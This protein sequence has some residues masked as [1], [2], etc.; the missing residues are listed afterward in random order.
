MIDNGIETVCNNHGYTNFDAVTDSTMS[1]SEVMTEINANRPFTVSMTYG[2]IA[3]GNTQPYG[4]HTVTCVGY[5]D[6]T[7]TDALYLHD[8]WDGNFVHG[9]TFGNW[10]SVVA[11]WVRP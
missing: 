6:G 8:T 9:I 2:G 3:S 4:N 1:M 5:A 11:T 10:G 7:T